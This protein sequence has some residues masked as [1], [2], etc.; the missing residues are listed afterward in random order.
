VRDEILYGML[1]PFAELLKFKVKRVH[2]LPMLD[3]ARQE[4]EDYMGR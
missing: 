4:F 1:Q 3:R 2:R